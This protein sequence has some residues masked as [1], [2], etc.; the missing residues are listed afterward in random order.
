MT[1]EQTERCLD[2]ENLD[3]LT[4]AELDTLDA[5]MTSVM[6]QQA[7][8]VRLDPHLLRRMLDGLRDRERALDERD[9]LRDGLTRV[10]GLGASGTD[11]G[12]GCAM[13]ARRVREGRET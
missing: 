12:A 11:D 3:T 9:R 10:E 4:E 5:R 7:T 8:K 6:N 13:L 1:D 2:E